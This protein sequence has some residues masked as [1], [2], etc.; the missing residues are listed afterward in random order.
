[1]L[2]RTAFHLHWE[3]WF[4]M[5]NLH[6]MSALDSMSWDLLLTAAWFFCCRRGQSYIQNTEY[7]RR[8]YADT[9]KWFPFTVP[10]SN[11]LLYWK[12][13]VLQ[14]IVF[15]VCLFLQFLLNSFITV[16]FYITFLPHLITL[17]YF[18]IYYLNHKMLIQYF[19]LLL[20][21]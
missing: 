1:M 19:S 12:T 6:N 17:V 7:G 13:D 4:L 20:I 16:R 9:L 2:I 14:L 11:L 3:R 18:L 21:Y 8:K 10:H 15:L 5:G